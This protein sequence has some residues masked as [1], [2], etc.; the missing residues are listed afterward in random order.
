MGAVD[1]SAFVQAADEIAARYGLGTANAPLELAARGEQ[2]L[3]WRLETPSGTYAVKQLEMQLTDDDVDADVAFQERAA[4]GAASYDVAST[5]RTTDGAILSSI[6]DRQVRVQTWLD[7]AG[8]DPGI[9]PALVGRMLAE[10][11]ACGEPRRGPVDAWYTEPVG[12]E[13]WQTY[14]DQVGSSYPEVAVRLDAAVRNQVAFER[15]IV[16]PGEL[17]T[18][19]RDLWADNVRLT[20]SGRL[21]VFDWDNCGPAD[22][23]HELAMVVWE[24]GLD[25]DERIETFIEVYEAAGGPGRVTGPGDFTMVI[26]QF[27]HFY[28]MAADPFLDPSATEADRAHGIE[29]FDEF[30][31]RPL[32]MEA[33]DQVIRVSRR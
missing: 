1:D 22:V 24:F 30:D 29:R 5:I 31:S 2:G 23:D 26:A 17:R 10:L 25:D 9:D 14:V 7:M 33:I 4:A 16:E 32:T 12:A 28:E 15:L 11:H 3:I 18:C 27:G 19:H 13:R 20:S 6:G 21:C 8:T